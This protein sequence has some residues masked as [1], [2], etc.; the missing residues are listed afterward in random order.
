MQFTTKFNVDEKVWVLYNNTIINS[1]L[2]VVRIKRSRYA[3]KEVITYKLAD[4]EEYVAE[5]ALYST[6]EEAAI[7]W[8]K[9]QDLKI[10]LI[11]SQEIKD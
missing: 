9:Q 6:K 10:A 7:A 5:E 8:L 11:N 2:E 3:L 4:L 1:R